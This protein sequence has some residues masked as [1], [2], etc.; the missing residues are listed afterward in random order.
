MGVSTVESNQDWDVSTC[1]DLVFQTVEK[2]STVKMFFFFLTVEI[3]TLD[4]DLNKN[5]EI[6]I[7]KVIETVET[8]F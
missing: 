6:S 8:R 3:E 5:W 2:I 1:W 4:R 7:L